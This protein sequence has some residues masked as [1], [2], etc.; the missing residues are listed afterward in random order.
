M[1]GIEMSKQLLKKHPNVKIIILTTHNDREIILE[2]LHIGVSGYVVKIPQN[3]SCL[4]RSK[5][6]KWKILF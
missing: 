3:K 6:K 2:M 5:S 4:L 1:D